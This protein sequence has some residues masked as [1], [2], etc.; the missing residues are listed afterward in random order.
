MQDVTSL[1]T[2]NE[3]GGRNSCIEE[4]DYEIQSKPT[5]PQ[6]EQQLGQPFLPPLRYDHVLN[7]KIPQ[8]Q[9]KLHNYAPPVSDREGWWRIT[10]KDSPN[11]GTYDT[12]LNTFIKEMISRPMTYGFKSDGRRRDPQPLEPKGKFLLPG[13]YSVEDFVERMHQLRL[14]YGF[15]GPDRQGLL[16]KSMAVNQDKNIDVPPG[17]YETQ[18][19]QTFDSAVESSRH[20]VFKSKTTRKIFLPK[21]G[22]APGD[23]EPKTSVTNEHSP[24]ITSAFRSST[25]RFHVKLSKIPG[26]GTYEKLANFPPPKQLNKLSMRGVF[27]NANFANQATNPI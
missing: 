23:Y 25:N 6:L 5:T 21:I 15:K 20:S 2:F 11:P 7:H 17:L 1:P 16:D 12:H 24:N 22:P 9:T 14:S 19:Y 10:I 8:R 13:A 26:P 18:K 27:F 3:N 4:T